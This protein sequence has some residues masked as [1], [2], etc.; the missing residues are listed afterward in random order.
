[1]T[2][3][4]YDNDGYPTRE[5]LDTIRNWGIDSNDDI[6][7]LLDFCGKAWTYPDLWPAETGR[8]DPI[9]GRRE[10]MVVATGGWSGNEDI[11]R[12]LQDNRPFWV[13]CWL[14]SRRGGGYKFLTRPLFERTQE[15]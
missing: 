14:E 5:T 1:M 4:T 12:A 6:A 8:E 9:L 2:E 3:P 10:W 13:F 15:A 7:A 11:I